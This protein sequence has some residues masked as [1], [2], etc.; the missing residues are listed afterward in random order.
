MVAKNDVIAFSA[1]RSTSHSLSAG[2]IVHF[3]KIWTNI[4]NEYDPKTGIFTAPRSGLYYFT[5]VIMVSEANRIVLQLFHNDSKISSGVM[6]RSYFTDTF[7]VLLSLEKRDTVSVKRSGNYVL[8]STG[9][10]YIS[11]SGYIS[12]NDN[13]NIC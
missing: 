3:N 5:S 9:D 2:A 13:F 10:S 6:N 8:H 1:Y 12:L 7:D 11:F 4:G